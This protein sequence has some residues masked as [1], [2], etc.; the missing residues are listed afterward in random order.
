M[1]GQKYQLTF[2]LLQQAQNSFQVWTSSPDVGRKDGQ[3]IS[4][5]VDVD[6]SCFHCLTNTI[7]LSDSTPTP[8]GH[9]GFEC[10]RV[11]WWEAWG[12][13]V[14]GYRDILFPI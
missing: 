14:H 9:S 5:L 3:E 13:S 1:L 6:E 7:H 11:E 10:P 12:L 8:T 2:Q 4:L